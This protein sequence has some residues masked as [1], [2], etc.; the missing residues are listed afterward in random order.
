MNAAAVISTV[1][2]LSKLVRELLDQIDHKDLTP[3]D[4]LRLQAE[5][6]DINAKL[7]SLRRRKMDGD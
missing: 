6:D 4:I 2:Q 5:K 1:L 7:E 3:A